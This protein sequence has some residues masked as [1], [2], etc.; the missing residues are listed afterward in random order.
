M[1]RGFYKIIKSA[2]V[3]ENIIKGTNRGNTGVII[4]IYKTFKIDI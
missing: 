4:A 2:R 3:F 1:A